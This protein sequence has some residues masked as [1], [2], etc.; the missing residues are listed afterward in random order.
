MDNKLKQYRVTCQFTTFADIPD[1]I[2]ATS[3]DDAK[4]QSMGIIQKCIDFNSI[5]TLD[6]IQ[7][8]YDTIDIQE[9]SGE[10]D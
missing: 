10:H 7:Y 5:S 9:C 3:I 4:K 8:A 2:E 1:V 6:N